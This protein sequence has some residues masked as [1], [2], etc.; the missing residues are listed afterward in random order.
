M[1]RLTLDEQIIVLLYARKLC[2]EDGMQ[3]SFSSGMCH[4]IIG[5]LYKF[6]NTYSNSS[7]IAMYIPTFTLSNIKKLTSGTKLY[8]D[9]EKFKPYWWN[10]EN[11]KVRVEVFNLL[12]DELESNRSFLYKW[13]KRLTYLFK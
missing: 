4:Y 8:P 12:L 2:K 9:E 3:S 5:N 6:H 1:A 7:G 13:Y 11:F 10:G